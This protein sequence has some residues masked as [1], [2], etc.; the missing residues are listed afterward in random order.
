MRD[1]TPV[2]SLAFSALLLINCSGGDNGPSGPT[3]PSDPSPPVFP[4]T[5]KPANVNATGD[6]GRTASARITVSGGT[7]QA[8]GS[9]GTVYT[10]T[11]PP[12][13][14]V[15]DTTISMTPLTGASGLELSGGRFIGVQFEP[16]GLQFFQKATCALLHPRDRPIP[17]SASWLMAVARR[18]TATR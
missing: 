7:L 15:G 14:L 18:F 11:I 12:D 9:D 13:A 10:L 8:S 5:P 16:D 2:A 17:R 6:P 3:G 1:L 4:Q